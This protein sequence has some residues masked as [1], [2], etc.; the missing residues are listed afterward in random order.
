MASSENVCLVARAIPLKTV[1]SDGKDQIVAVNS[2]A[3]HLDSLSLGLKQSKNETEKK[4]EESRKKMR[5]EANISPA[6]HLALQS[7]RSSAL[8]RKTNTTTKLT[9]DCRK[10]FADLMMG[11]EDGEERQ[12]KSNE[13]KEKSKM[14][15]ADEKKKEQANCE[16]KEQKKEEKG[17]ENGRERGSGAELMA[18]GPIRVPPVVGR[19]AP[20]TVF[21][22]YASSAAHPNAQSSPTNDFM[23][24]SV[25]FNA[26]ALQSTVFDQSSY[27]SMAAAGYGYECGLPSNWSF[28]CD[29]V[30]SSPSTTP[31]TVSA[32]SPGDRSERSEL[33]DDLSDF[34]LEY[35]R[36]YS[37]ELSRKCSLGS[38]GIAGGSPLSDSSTD[39]DRL[40]LSSGNSPLCAPQTSPAAP[41]GGVANNENSPQFNTKGTAKAKEKPRPA[42]ERLRAMIRSEDMDNAWA[43]TC[44]CIQRHPMALHF[45]DGDGDTLLH[46]VMAHLDFA[47]IYALVE[48]MLKSEEAP[49]KPLLFDIPN[50]MGETPYK[51]YN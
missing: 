38:Q 41:R 28:G 43:W 20:S 7:L 19:G 48:Q 46:I 49:Q 36:R 24:A 1:S 5:E 12:K 6:D 4:G 34:I 25:S 50:R 21:H 51:S 40:S 47:K 39:D 37:P 3:A 31:D 10:L 14:K 42:K 27:N 30:L 16:K 11:E 32:M 15:E 26:T 18:R 35:S 2:L 8:A 17:G 44:K 9:R 45:Q 22:P 29:S 33:P 13:K 23:S